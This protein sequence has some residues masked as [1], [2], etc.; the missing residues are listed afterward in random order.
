[1]KSLL[2]FSLLVVC[3]S[4]AFAQEINPNQKHG[5]TSQDDEATIIYSKAGAFLVEAPKGWI[6]DTTTGKRLGL[7]C[8]YYPEGSTWDTAGT[9]MYPNIATKGPGQETLKEFMVHDLASFREHDPG[10]R[11]V[12]GKDI[13][14]KHNR[15]AMLRYFFG[16]NKSSSEAVAYVDEEKMISVLVVSSKTENGLNKSIPLLRQMLGTYYFMYVKNGNEEKPA[17]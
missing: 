11:Y 10:L 15:I 16:V 13:P 4:P 1:M 5:S 2:W 6:A 8:V 14:L 9:V 17:K 3:L 7:C 12:D